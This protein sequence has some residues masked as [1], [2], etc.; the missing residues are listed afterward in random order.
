MLEHN[1]NDAALKE[2]TFRT[3][4][5]NRGRTFLSGLRAFI[6]RSRGT[7][8]PLLPSVKNWSLS[9]ITFDGSSR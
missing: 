4:L 8:V 9:D 7:C 2:D 3:G 6:M 1:L 5:E